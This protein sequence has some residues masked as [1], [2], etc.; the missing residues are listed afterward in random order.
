MIKYSEILPTKELLG[1]I[2]LV[3]IAVAGC[4]TSAVRENHEKSKEISRLHKVAVIPLG[5]RSDDVTDCVK[6]TLQRICPALQFYPHE[7]FVDMLYP[8][9]EPDTAPK[10]KEDLEALFKNRLVQERIASLDVRYVIT[11][12]GGTSQSKFEGWMPDY[13]TLGTGYQTAERKTDIYATVCDLK[14]ATL[15]LTTESHRYQTHKY[16]WW[17]VFPIY[18]YPAITETPACNE[19]GEKLAIQLQGC[20]SSVD[21]QDK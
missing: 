11:I 19:I 10:S 21:E 8:W 9:F 12:S 7:E 4:A 14:E 1:C 5:K 17:L 3:F 16:L 20:N 13:F 15:P 6:N 2:L 18:I